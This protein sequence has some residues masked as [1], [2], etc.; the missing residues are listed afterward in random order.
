MRPDGKGY[1]YCGICGYK[2]KEIKNE[3]DPV[4]NLYKT[5]QPVSKDNWSGSM[6]NIEHTLEKDY[7][8]GKR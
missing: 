8:N 6:D 5:L 2:I 4:A 3:K 7:R 1:L